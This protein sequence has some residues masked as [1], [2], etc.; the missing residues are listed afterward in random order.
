MGEGAAEMALPIDD[1]ELM[2]GDITLDSSSTTDDEFTGLLVFCSLL[3]GFELLTGM[4]P[5]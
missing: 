5:P 4:I 3:D 1:V 2:L